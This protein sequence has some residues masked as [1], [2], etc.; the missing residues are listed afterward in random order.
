MYPR[1]AASPERIAIGPVVQ[2]SDGAVQTSGVAVKVI[3]FGQSEASGTGTVAYSA[4]GVVLYTPVQ[5]ETNYTSF[6]L[7]ASKSGC[8]PATQTIVT[9]AESTAGTVSANVTK[10]GGT[11]QTAGD[12]AA[13]I[14]TL[15]DYVDTEVAAIKAKTDNLPTDPADASDI[16]ASFS[17]VN[18]TLATIAGYVDTEVASIKSTVDALA[19]KLGGITLLKNWLGALAGKTADSS[20]LAEI[21]ATTAGAGF[22]NT[23]DSLEA[24]ADA[25]GGGGSTD[26]TANERTAIR[27]I[28]GIPASGTTPD[29]PTD[30]VLS[31]IAATLSGTPIEATSRVAS[32]GTITAYIGDDFRVRSDTEL[33]ISTSDV[34][35]VLYTKWTAIGEENLYFGASREGSDA[36][37]ISGTVAAITSVGS[38][39]SQT[40]K[41]TVEITNCG[42]GLKPGTYE[43]QIEQRQ[44]HGSDTDSFIEIAGSLILK[45]NSV[46]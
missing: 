3:P 5:A 35:G 8:I 23:T 43:Y 11:S 10:V 7:I 16:S 4:D 9:T 1:N 25:G 42:S 38:G 27:T 15:D 44:A 39:A 24:Q 37:A 33:S 13:L 45:R 20:T 2:I 19:T 17:T 31:D 28:L 46:A 21:N 41:L 40:V 30:G 22:N 29:S 34:G 6:V 14:N 26:W 32:G 36:G 18:S 12:L